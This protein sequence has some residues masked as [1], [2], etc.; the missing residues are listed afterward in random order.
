MKAV[1]SESED[2][3]LSE[4]S[5]ISQEQTASIKRSFHFVRNFFV[6]KF[7]LLLTMQRKSKLY[8][9]NLTLILFY[10]TLSII[11][12]CQCILCLVSG[13]KVKR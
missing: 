2:S 1:K 8:S 4:C 12:L 13:L 10:K 11:I 3:F 7:V 9:L 6:L 5:Q